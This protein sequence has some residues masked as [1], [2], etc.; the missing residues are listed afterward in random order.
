MIKT[1]AA[2][3]K[4][5]EKLMAKAEAE[6]KQALADIEKQKASAA[7]QL[8]RSEIRLKQLEVKSMQDQQAA[9]NA[10]TNRLRALAA[11][12]L[13]QKRLAQAQTHLKNETKAKATLEAQLPTAKAATATTQRAQQ[14]A[15]GAF[16][17]KQTAFNADK[18]AVDAA[19]AA[20]RVP[21]LTRLE[22][23]EKALQQ[24]K[25][26][27]DVAGK[28]LANDTA[29]LAALTQEKNQLAKALVDQ[30][31]AHDDK[32]KLVAKTQMTL[33]K[34]E[35]QAMMA[36]QKAA[37]S[38]TAL[39]NLV[40]GKQDPVLA[41]YKNATNM[42]AESQAAKA[43]ASELLKNM[44]AEV[45]VLSK[46]TQAA[47]TA[48]Q[49]A[50]SESQTVQKDSKKSDSEK[51]AA[52]KKSVAIRQSADATKA[53]LT[54][55]ETEK[56]KPALNQVAV[57]AGMLAKAM[58]D[59]DKAGKVL[60]GLAGEIKRG[61]DMFN[62]D[63]Q[64]ARTETAKAQVSAKLYE[65]LK[66]DL[67]FIAKQ[68][69]EAAK[70]ATAAVTAQGNFDQQQMKPAQ[71]LDLKNKQAVANAENAKKTA[72]QAMAAADA[73]IKRLTQSR[74]T[75]ETNLAAA[76]VVLDKAMA[77]TRQAQEFQMKLEK[78]LADRQ[79]SFISASTEKIAREKAKN[80]AESA[81][82]QVEK[83]V[84]AKLKPA[85]ESKAILDLESLLHQ[86]L[87]Q[88]LARELMEKNAALQELRI[89]Q[90]KDLASAA[91]V[92]Q[93]SKKS[94]VEQEK[95]LIAATEKL[96]AVATAVQVAE[97]G[98]KQAE[99]DYKNHLKTLAECS[100]A[101]QNARGNISVLQSQ[102]AAAKAALHKFLFAKR[103]LLNLR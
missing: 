51:D 33:A 94:L 93:A 68:R 35:A 87:E 57:T 82:K 59:Q 56:L 48:A 10:A 54:N 1:V 102:R 89:L 7:A 14:T 12:A 64:A 103:A 37:S 58:A 20:K 46:A 74:Q 80:Q 9:G 23:A 52:K 24:A 22:S 61:T 62:R 41:A 88:Q 15:Q 77:L 45:A 49:V 27:A 44:Q 40:A 70:T 67:A 75:A 53:T 69:D 73:G 99:L 47:E 83:D 91:A 4:T 90:K 84:L 76:K 2:A 100:K 26:A 21:A 36:R 34:S 50:E 66:T 5:H 19:V 60:D 72:I 42:V 86:E 63:D 97:A 98:L 55:L 38:R 18:T 71:A 32:R 8:K 101:V 43:K 79:K 13:E 29:A 17:A 30:G 6:E 11:L 92:H 78:Q 85:A 65:T 28:K 96:K 39:V 81:S 3:K 25:L 16:N 31:K 95:E